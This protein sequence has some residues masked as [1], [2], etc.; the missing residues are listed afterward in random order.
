MIWRGAFHLYCLQSTD[1]FACD[2]CISVCCRERR[3]TLFWRIVKYAP[4]LIFLFFVC[5]SVGVLPVIWCGVFALVLS[6]EHRSFFMWYI[7]IG[8]S[9]YKYHFCRDKSMPVTTKLLSRQTYFSRDKSFVMTNIILSRQTY[10]VMKK[11]LS[12]Q[13]YFCRNK[14][15][16]CRDKNN[17]C[18]SSRPWAFCAVTSFCAHF[19]RCVCVCVFFSFSFFCCNCHFQVLSSISHLLISSNAVISVSE[20]TWIWLCL[21]FCNFRFSSRSAN[22]M[23]FC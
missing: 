3:I 12:R 9:C 18:G 4:H 7:I 10:F 21:H 17:T 11:V 8:G 20:S 13:A 19:T 16:D 6:A 1:Q 15:R 23:V 22:I 2:K 5:V 14:R